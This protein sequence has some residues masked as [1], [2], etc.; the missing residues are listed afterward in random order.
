M[1]V[2]QNQNNGF[3]EKGLK[4]C[5]AS[6][7]KNIKNVNLLEKSDKPEIIK[8]IE[9]NIMKELECFVSLFNAVSN[10]RDTM[11]SATIPSS[12]YNDLVNVKGKLS[13]INQSAKKC[14]SKNVIDFHNYILTRV[15]QAL[16]I[17]SGSEVK[18]TKDIPNNLKK[19]D[20]QIFIKTQAITFWHPFVGEQIQLL[21]L[22]PP[23][24][25]QPNRVFSFT[26]TLYK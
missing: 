22:Q 6:I 1:E 16:E 26:S 10:L 3:I 23:P 20:F 11:E 14:L 2:L 25:E 15:M 4:D 21:E 8:N 24:Y 13:D 19:I 18:T 9:T 7:N 17:P 12:L 5:I